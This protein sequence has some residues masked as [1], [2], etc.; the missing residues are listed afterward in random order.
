MVSR[1]YP[2]PSGIRRSGWF[3]HSG[4]LGFWD[5]AGIWLLSISS[6]EGHGGVIN[7]LAVDNTYSIE[8]FH[9]G[10]ESDCI[11]ASSRNWSAGDLSISNCAWRTLGPTKGKFGFVTARGVVCW[12]KT[13]RVHDRFQELSKGW[14]MVTPLWSVRGAVRCCLGRVILME[15]EGTTGV[16]D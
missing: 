11:L 8:Y 2:A 3:W 14:E 4:D 9:S 7:S 13:L 1:P 6:W 16:P 5:M 12:M 15:T 10:M